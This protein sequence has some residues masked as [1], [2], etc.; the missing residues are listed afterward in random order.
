MKARVDPEACTACGLC[1]DGC[2]EVFTMGESAAEALSD[3]V[4]AA[5]EARVRAAAE[6]CPVEAIRVED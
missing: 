2:P 1:V 3:P 5:L 6:G 4:P